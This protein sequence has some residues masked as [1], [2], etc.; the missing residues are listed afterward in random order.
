MTAFTNKLLQSFYWTNVRE[1]FHSLAPSFKYQ[2]NIKLMVIA[3]LWVAIDKGFGLD[4]MAFVGLLVA[5]VT[6]LFSGIMAALIRKEK[7]SSMKLSRF[8]LKVTCYMALIFISYTMSLSFKSHNN[9]LAF[10]VFD[11]LHI[12]LIVQIVFENVISILEN[13]AV[14]SGKD[15]AHWIEKLTEKLNSLFS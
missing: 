10:W 1:F 7:F 12:F 14:I 8:L 11:W 5:F 15:K 6:E 4:G 13:I 2:L 9:E 3:S